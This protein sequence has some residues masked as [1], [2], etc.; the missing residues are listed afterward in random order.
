VTPKPFILCFEAHRADG[1]V[2]SI[3]QGGKWRTAHE[4]Y[5]DVPVRTVYV[6]LQTRQPKAY[7]MGT[8]VVHEQY[9]IVRDHLN[10]RIKHA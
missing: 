4:I 2:W 9:D 5:I 8:G 1:K 10:L 3:R 6:G 7:L